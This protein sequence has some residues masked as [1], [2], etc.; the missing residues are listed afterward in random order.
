MSN[1]EI[2]DKQ[3]IKRLIEPFFKDMSSHITPIK[4]EAITPDIFAFLFRTTGKD[5]EEH[6]F[7]SLEFDYIENTD[8]TGQIIEN[9]HGATIINFWT[10]ESNAEDDNI[11]VKISNIYYAVLAEV[12]RPKGSGYWAANLVINNKESI[13]DIVDSLAVKNKDAIRKSINDIFDKNPD[14]EISV[15]LHEDGTTDYYYS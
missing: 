11:R 10:P 6:Y 5:K 4:Y 2:F 15:Y 7:V 9:W 12:E 14:V 13:D 3:Q 8:K 1:F